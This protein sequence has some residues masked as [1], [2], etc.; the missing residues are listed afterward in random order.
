MPKPSRTLQ[1]IL[2]SAIIVASAFGQAG[3][4][5]PP[6]S[7]DIY[8]ENPYEVGENLLS[9]HLGC[10]FPMT[11]YDPSAGG[12]ES[13]NLK[14]PGA[15]F[16][17]EYARTVT[18]GFALGGE[19]S[20][21]IAGSVALRTLFMVPTFF[22]ATWIF[23]ALPFEIMPSAG[24]GFSFTKLQDMQRIDPALEAG[25]GFYWRANLDWSFGLDTNL[26]LVSQ[27]YPDAAQNRVGFFGEATLAAVYH[28]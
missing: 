28:F 25:C 27:F 14:L 26:V 1:I 5:P 13:T 6:P 19:V 3:D 15:A 8:N 23:V 20:G 22:K 17:L 18:R 9:V 21:G 4:E 16:S 11:F 24:L 12:F 2:F 7:S 10:L